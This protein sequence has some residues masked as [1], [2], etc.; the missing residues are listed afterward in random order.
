MGALGDG[1]VLQDD[2][3]YVLLDADGAIVTRGDGDCECC[4]AGC[5]DEWPDYIVV[6]FHD[7]RLCPKVELHTQEYENTEYGFCA[8][9]NYEGECVASVDIT[10]CSYYLKQDQYVSEGISINGL[11]RLDHVGGGYYT[12]VIEDAY[13]YAVR[14]VQVCTDGCESCN[15]T[16]C[17]PGSN[18]DTT[19][20]SYADVFLEASCGDGEWSLSATV[21]SIVQIFSGHGRPSFVPNADFYYYC[22]APVDPGMT[23]SCSCPSEGGDSWSYPQRTNDAVVP[24]CGGGVFLYQSVEPNPSEVGYRVLRASLAPLC[25]GGGYAVITIPPPP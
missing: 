2:D 19:D 1:A 24:L 6:E 20:R 15:P 16:R 13:E 25:T 8:T 14:N 23:V 21:P 7:L 22:D 18:Y 3:G 4:T 11:L 10:P 17:V 9:L 5:P 12:G